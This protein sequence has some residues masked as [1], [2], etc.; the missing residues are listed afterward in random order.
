MIAIN[1]FF[2]SLFSLTFGGEIITH[3]LLVRLRNVAGMPGV[4]NKSCVVW[5]ENLSLSQE[6]VETHG[7]DDQTSHSNK[8]NCAENPAN[9]NSDNFELAIKAAAKIGSQRRYGIDE[10]NNA[11]NLLM[12]P[13][14]SCSD[15]GWLM[16]PPPIPPPP[17]RTWRPW[18][19]IPQRRESRGPLGLTGRQGSVDGTSAL[20]EVK[21]TSIC[22]TQSKEAMFYVIYRV[23]RLQ[24][25][26][27]KFESRF[28]VIAK[29]V[30]FDNTYFFHL[31]ILPNMSNS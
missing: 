29:D 13:P 22:I 10:D 23:P 28:Y 7:E 31:S 24:K 30:S 19:E 12:P 9:D 21:D 15:D 6:K 4:F 20:I 1:L 11:P 18:L 5:E 14:Q 2:S 26:C 16:P 17:K 27:L 8:A 25:R 3:L